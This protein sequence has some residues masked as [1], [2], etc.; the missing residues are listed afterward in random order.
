YSGARASMYG[1]WGP[2][3]NTTGIKVAPGLAS[4][5]AAKAL[6]DGAPTD[7]KALRGKIVTGVFPGS[8]YIQEPSSVTAEIVSFGSSFTLSR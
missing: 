2:A 7:V 8:F 1:N 3:A 6:A 4:I 5:Q